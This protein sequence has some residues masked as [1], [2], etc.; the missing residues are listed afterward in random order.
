LAKASETLKKAVESLL[1]N[2]E[3]KAQSRKRK[4]Q[5]LLKMLSSDTS[6]PPQTDSTP[7]GPTAKEIEQQIK[8]SPS[9]RRISGGSDF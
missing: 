9:P 5:E 7:S 3:T 2:E 6:P 4:V 8:D 1:Q